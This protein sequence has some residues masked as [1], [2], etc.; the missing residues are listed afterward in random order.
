MTTGTK[1]GD[2]KTVDIC[3]FCFSHNNMMQFNSTKAYETKYVT[4][5][6]TLVNCA[7]CGDRIEYVKKGSVITEV[8]G[9]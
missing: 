9:C 2:K 7:F 3:R 5:P 8:R 6:R 4:K 1:Y